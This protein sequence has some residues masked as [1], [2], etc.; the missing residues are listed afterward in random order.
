MRTRVWRQVIG[1]ALT[2]CIAATAP[3]AVT[4]IKAGRLLDPR[5]RN[6]LLPAEVIIEDG[7]IKQVGPPTKV[8]GQ[9]PSDATMIDLGNATLLPGLIDS[10]THLLI[11]PIAPAEV[12]TDGDTELRD[13]INAGR[14]PGPRIL[15]SGRKLISRASYIQNLNPALGVALLACYV[16]ARRAMNVDPMVALRCE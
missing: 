16:S 4:A 12:G 3:G 5:T 11:D 10:H 14:V 8:Q 7:K 2:S 15:A 13:A 1:F 6:V 9:M